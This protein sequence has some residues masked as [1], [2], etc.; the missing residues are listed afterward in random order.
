MKKTFTKLMILFGAM[1]MLT[2]CK[3]V[4]ENPV[5]LPNVALDINDR[6]VIF[7]YLAKGKTGLFKLDLDSEEVSMW[8]KP[9]EGLIY[10]PKY[11]IDGCSLTYVASE[12]INGRR[13]NVIY[14]MDQEAGSKKEILRLYTYII[15]T[16]L[17]Q[18]SGR[19]YFTSAAVL[20]NSSPLA[21][22]GAKIM[23]VY[24]VDTT[25]HDLRN[26]TD[27][28]AYSIGGNLA[29]SPSGEHLF[30]SVIRID[31]EHRIDKKKSGPYSYNLRT[32]QETSLSPVNKDSLHNK[33]DNNFL[34]KF[35]RPVPARDPGTFFLLSATTVYKVNMHDMRGEFFY[36]QSEDDRVKHR[37]QVQSFIPFHLDRK[38]LMMKQTGEKDSS[39]FI[40]NERGEVIKVITPDM[41]QFRQY[42][43]DVIAIQK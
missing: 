23:D 4:K 39:F 11:A 9:T 20:G 31:P 28:G 19:I 34:E 21:K 24:S 26:E 12:T 14:L 38:Y 43:D 1:H 15:D 33:I 16:A 37:Y 32:K 40:L 7:P 25:G 8:L 36:T 6:H 27:L 30:F 3:V 29:F 17:K 41:E 18:G 10:A 42:F 35:L 5:I 22:P 2:G 13:S